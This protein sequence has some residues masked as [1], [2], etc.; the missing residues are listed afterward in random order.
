MTKKLIAIIAAIPFLLTAWL[1][2][3]AQEKDA[4]P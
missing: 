4:P 2:V 1:T 3:N